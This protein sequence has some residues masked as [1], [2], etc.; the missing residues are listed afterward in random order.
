MAQIDYY[1]F[2][3]SPYTYLAGADLEEIAARRGAAITYKPMQLMRIFAE[4]GTAAVKDRPECRQ[5]YRLADI[6]RTA[7]F[8]GMAVNPKP[9]FFPTNPVPASAAIIAAQEAGGGDVGLLCQKILSAVWAGDKDIAQDEVVA[10]CLTA[11]GFDPAIAGKGLLS[12]VETLER[13]TDEA[14]R[15]GVFGSPTYMVGDELFWGQDRLPQLDTF[16]AEAG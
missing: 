3:L 2:P 7:R 5:T 12:S 6:A 8:R 15:R 9:A 14:L 4:T 11:A 16:L 10:D 1:L 13:N